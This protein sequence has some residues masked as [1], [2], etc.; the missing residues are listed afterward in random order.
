[1]TFRRFAYVT[2]YYWYHTQKALAAGT[3]VYISPGLNLVITGLQ[4][5][6]A[7]VCQSADSTKHKLTQVRPF[8]RPF[9]ENETSSPWCF[10]CLDCKPHE[11]LVK[12]AGLIL[13]VACLRCWRALTLISTPSQWRHPHSLPAISIGHWICQGVSIRQLGDKG[14]R[15]FIPRL[16]LIDLNAFRRGSK[17]P[18]PANIR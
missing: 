16:L 3:S 11:R 1:M 8:Q 5:S 4:F 6:T 10:G 2:N 7:S 13:I 12:T 15:F 18:H 9:P 14:P 17:N